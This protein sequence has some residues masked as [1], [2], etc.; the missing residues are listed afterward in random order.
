MNDVL[1]LVPEIQSFPLL[2][3]LRPYPYHY[4]P[5][6]YVVNVLEISVAQ[7]ELKGFIFLVI[8]MKDVLRFI[9]DIQSFLLLLTLRS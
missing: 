6:R 1:M 2:F 8:K 9:P 5:T 4:L 7:S 3:T